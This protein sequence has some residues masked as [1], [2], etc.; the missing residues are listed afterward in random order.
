[1]TAPALIPRNA[2]AWL[3]TAQVV[4]LIPQLPRLPLWVS[5]LWIVCAVWRVQ[6]Q[7]MRWTYPGTL[8]K[9]LAMLLA[10]AGVFAAQGTLLGLDAAVM[11]LL[12]LFMLKLLEMRT[13]RDA[14]VVIYLGFFIV[15][16]AFLFDQS[17]LLA[18][19]Q[20]FSVLV[21]V[22]GLVGLQQTPGRND[23][24]RALRTGG[25]LLL[26]AVPLMLV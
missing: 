21:L 25:V 4:V 8:I 24:A 14:L 7:R 17:I 13:P 12:L 10:I 1:M 5:V 23:P 19:Y 2:L 3:L 22:A 26:Q 16:T 6:I 20:C 9:T 15:A 11:L 18:L